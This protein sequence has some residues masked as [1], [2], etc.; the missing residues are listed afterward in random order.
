MVTGLFG[1]KMFSQC[2]NQSQVHAGANVW[3]Q[4]LLENSKSKRGQNYARIFEDYLPYWYGF[5]FESKQLDWVFKVN[6]FSNDRDIGK[7][8][9]L[10]ENV[11]VYWKLSKF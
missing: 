9:S 3:L 1:S 11:K 8:Q 7:C 2:Q 6:I 10:L 5:P 4:L